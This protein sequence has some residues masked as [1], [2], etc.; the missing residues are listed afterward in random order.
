MKNILIE[1]SIIH[2]SLILA[3]WLILRNEQKHG[4][5]RGYLILAALFSLIIPL[6]KLPKLFSA[7]EAVAIAPT[8]VTAPTEA[9]VVVPTVVQPFWN[10]QLL[11]TIYFVISGL[12]LCK[13]LFNI[14]H[15][16]HLERKSQLEHFNGS[17]IR[18]TD[19]SQVSFT[20]FN[21]IFL[22]KD[23]DKDE[24]EYKV[25]LKHEEAHSLLFHTYDLILF[26]L[27]TA[28]FWWLPSAWFVQKEIKKIH[29]YQADAYALKSYD[30]NHYASILI[31]STLK[32]H[33]HFMMV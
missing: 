27:Y 17:T 24:Q 29:E 11:L 30:V 19:H 32:S 3:Y 18:R 22:S 25:I 23:I 14:F 33:T 5:Q 7:T 1:L 28:C 15:L 31:S 6:L 26:E 12:F 4:H 21:W 13:F 16:I 2:L 8:V 20:F 9:A 10:D